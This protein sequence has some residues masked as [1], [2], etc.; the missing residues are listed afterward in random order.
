[1]SKK[2]E[3]IY[4]KNKFGINKFDFD[5]IENKVNNKD[6]QSK[7]RYLMLKLSIAAILVMIVSFY[8]KD[9]N[10]LAGGF[11]VFFG[12]LSV[13]LLILFLIIL[14]N[15]KKAIKDEC[16]KVYKKNTYNRKSTP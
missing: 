15:P 16:F 4:S 3:P 10:G 8:F 13:I 12:V 11:A 2:N 14:A 7:I 6:E 1:M 9:E 5:S